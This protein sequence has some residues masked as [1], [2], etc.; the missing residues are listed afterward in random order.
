MLCLLL[1]LQHKDVSSDNHDFRTVIT[2]GG[3]PLL[4]NSL[5]TMLNLH[6]HFVWRTAQSATVSFLYILTLKFML[7]FFF[8]AHDCLYSHAVNSS[9]KKYKSCLTSYIMCY[10]WWRLHICKLY[11]F[12]MSLEF[13]NFSSLLCILLFSHWKDANTQILPQHIRRRG[14]RSA[15]HFEVSQGVISQYYYHFGLW[16]RTYGYTAW[17]THVHKCMFHIWPL[18]V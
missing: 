10:A 14:H 12:K 18:F 2:C 13:M 5:K 7:I 17:E 15:L 11:T 1:L 9:V 16:P 8:F 6:W 3:I 4:Q